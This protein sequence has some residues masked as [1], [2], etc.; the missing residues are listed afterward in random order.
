MWQ[1]LSPTIPQLSRHAL[2]QH[3]VTLA[4]VTMCCFSAWRVAWGGWLIN[5]L[6]AHL[7]SGTEYNNNNNHYYYYLCYR[8]AHSAGPY[9][10]SNLCLPG[11]LL[12]WT[13]TR[14]Y[15]CV[16][17]PKVTEHQ[18]QLSEV[19][20]KWSS[21]LAQK[22]ALGP[23]VDEQFP[24]I[25]RRTVLW[26]QPSISRNA[27]IFIYRTECLRIVETARRTVG[28]AQPAQNVRAS[29]QGER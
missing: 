26:T 27:H 7:F 24:K 17:N 10:L 28:W 9:H 11:L 18:Q 13:M 25:G 4:G 19:N 3:M 21:K 8:F 5:Y 12:S 6:V 1:K 22:G 23:L 14:S 2:E 16:N 29:I 20:S 15:S